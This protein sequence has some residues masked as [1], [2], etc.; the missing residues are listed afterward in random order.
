VP[1]NLSKQQENKVLQQI[2]SLSKRDYTVKLGMLLEEAKRLYYCKENFKI[3]KAALN[4][5]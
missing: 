4:S 1:L 2:D 5:E 3:L